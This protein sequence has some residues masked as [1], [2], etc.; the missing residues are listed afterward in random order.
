MERIESED[1]RSSC[2]PLRFVRPLATS[3]DRPSVCMQSTGESTVD[4]PP[5]FGVVQ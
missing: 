5:L 2:V 3:R 1:V 4:S